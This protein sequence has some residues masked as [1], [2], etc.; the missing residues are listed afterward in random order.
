MLKQYPTMAPDLQPKAIELLTQ[1]SA[2]SKQL[3]GEIDAKKIPSSALNV[4]QVRK[5]LASKDA[6]L[7]KR[8]TSV[9]GTVRDGRNP[10]REKVVADMRTLLKKTPGDVTRG[11]AIFKKICAQCHKLHGEGADVGPDITS[12]GRNDYEQLL[13]NVFDPSLVIGAG[14]RATRVVTTSGKIVD[15]LVGRG[16]S[17]SRRAQDARRQVG[18]DPARGGRRN[19]DEPAVVHAGGAGKADDAAGDRGPVRGDHARPAAG[20]SAGPEDTGDA[21]TRF[22]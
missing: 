1:R 21:V 16:Q 18:D 15:G 13:S 2:W 6:D 11:Q 22:I 10:E 8:V 19:E 3:L 5:L 4:N 7:V 14:F 20:G 12:N 9:W 17:E